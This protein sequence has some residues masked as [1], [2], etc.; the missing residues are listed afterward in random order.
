LIKDKTL[1]VFNDLEPAQA[2]PLKGAALVALRRINGFL[3]I[4][5]TGN[6]SNALLL[7]TR[8]FTIVVWQARRRSV[9]L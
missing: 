4:N 1:L 2:R 8:R 9:Y 5:M 3:S 7:T 6:N